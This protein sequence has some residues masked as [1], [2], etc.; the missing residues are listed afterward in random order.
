MAESVYLLC[1]ILSIACAV[2]LLRGYRKTPSHLLLWS[3]ACFGLMAVNN[4]ILFTD[5]VLLPDV[6]FGGVVLRNVTGATA[7]SLLL[8]GLIW[9]LS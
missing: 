5:V 3:S 7:G 2:M 8:F 1:T 6:D 4:I 9:E